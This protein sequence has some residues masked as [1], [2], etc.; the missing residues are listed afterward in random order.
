MFHSYHNAHRSAAKFRK[1]HN[2]WGLI[3]PPTMQAYAANN[4]M[5]VS[6]NNSSRP[7]SSWPSFFVRPDGVITA[8]LI[9]NRPGMHNVLRAIQVAPEVLTLDELLLNPKLCEKVAK[10]LRKEKRPFEISG[11]EAAKTGEF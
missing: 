11:E 4:Y 2:I 7:R 6:A 10:R 1:Y 8:K 5:W 3:V 9:N